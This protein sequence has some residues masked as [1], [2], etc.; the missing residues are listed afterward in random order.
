[1]SVTK[2]S[3]ISKLLGPYDLGAAG[4]VPP[5]PPNA[6]A[7][8]DVLLRLHLQQ[9]MYTA[10]H[11]G[12]IYSSPTC[13]YMI[14]IRRLDESDKLEHHTQPRIQGPKALAPAHQRSRNFEMTSC[15]LAAFH[16]P[17]QPWRR[18]LRC[19]TALGSGDEADRRRRIKARG[20]VGLG[21]TLT[22]RSSWPSRELASAWSFTSKY[23]SVLGCKKSWLGKQ[24]VDSLHG[25]QWSSWAD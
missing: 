19:E 11:P 1:V 12:Y 16:S 4:P 23:P 10:G 8:V 13:G 20:D 24:I 9:Y 6:A 3:K 22:A 25:R 18:S 21:K 17:L 7:R 2:W 15:M 5:V 14:R